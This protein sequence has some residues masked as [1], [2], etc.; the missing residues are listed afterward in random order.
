MKEIQ[1]DTKLW[2]DNCK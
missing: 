2:K 1:P